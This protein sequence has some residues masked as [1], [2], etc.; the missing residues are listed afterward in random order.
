MSDDSDERELHHH[1]HHHGDA[2]PA[3]PDRTERRPNGLPVARRSTSLQNPR[4]GTLLTG[5]LLGAG[6]TLFLGNE[7]VQRSVLR[8]AVRLWSG[9]QAGVEEFKERL[10]DA[11]AEVHAAAPA[12]S[13]S[14]PVE[15][16][17]ERPND[18]AMEAGLSEPPPGRH[19]GE[20]G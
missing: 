12:P 9:M 18:A 3:G 17:G 8:G 6:A 19:S 7:R 14:P 2:A 1:Y 20:P 10:N 15:A 4:T 5:A 11:Q 16:A 13:Q